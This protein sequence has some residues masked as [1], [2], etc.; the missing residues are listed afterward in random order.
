MRQQGAGS[1]S[2]QQGRSD[3]ARRAAASAASAWLRAVAP[4]PSQETRSTARGAQSPM[5][6][7]GVEVV[8]VAMPL[9]YPWR[10]AYGSDPVI[11]SVLVKLTSSSGASAWGESGLSQHPLSSAVIAV[12]R[13]RCATHAHTAL[14]R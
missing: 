2:R 7:N 5:L 3:R 1:S 11:E 9:I 12:R 13:S 14:R 6:V 4:S 8:H 10:T